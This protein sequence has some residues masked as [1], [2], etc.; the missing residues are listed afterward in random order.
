MNIY[1]IY[2]DCNHD[3]EVHWFIPHPQLDLTFI[4][5]LQIYTLIMFAF[6]L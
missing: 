4:T 2:K 6:E 3:S 5:Q 1:N